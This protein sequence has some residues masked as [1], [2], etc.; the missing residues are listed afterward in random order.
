MI[1]EL[2]VYRV[3][4]GRMADL[5]AR[6][7]H[8]S[9]TSLKSLLPRRRRSLRPH[10]AKPKDGCSVRQERLPNWGCR[11]LPSIRRSSR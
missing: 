11:E 3:V 2:R 8:Q 6:F 10:S 7:E 1:Y 9:L 4:Q 5:L